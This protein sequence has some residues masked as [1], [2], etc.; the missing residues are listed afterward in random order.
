MSDIVFSAFTAA[1]IGF[2][3]FAGAGVL[4]GFAWVGFKNW[5]QKR[6]NSKK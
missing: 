3:I 6:G 4:A 1:A 2:M 5:R